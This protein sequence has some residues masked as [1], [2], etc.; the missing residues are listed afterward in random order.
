MNPFVLLQQIITRLRHPVYR[1]FY[2]KQDG[3]A[4]L[5][6][7]SSPK[8]KNN[9]GN[10]RL[11]IEN[12]GVKCLCYNRGAPRSFNYAGILSLTKVGLLE[13]LA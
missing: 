6:Y 7:I 2:V 8:L 9:F 1:C 11:G 5:Y 12:K 4:G 3:S 10:A 13:D